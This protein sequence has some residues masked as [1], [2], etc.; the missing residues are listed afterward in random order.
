MRTLCILLLSLVAGTVAADVYRSVDENGV[1]TFS[2][3][4]G[5]ADTELII[6][7]TRPA[8]PAPDAAAARPATPDSAPEPEADAAGPAAAEEAPSPQEVAEERRR[9]CEIAMERIDRY[10]RAR[11]LYRALPDG[12]REYLSDEDTAAAR[13]DAQADVATWCS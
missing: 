5:G 11:R 12:E 9:N 4:P 7:A 3:R 13:A 6:V 2:D 8:T 1:V 10:S